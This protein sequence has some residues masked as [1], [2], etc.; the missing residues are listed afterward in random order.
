MLIPLETAMKR[1]CYVPNNSRPAKMIADRLV[2][3]KKP[4]R[5]RYLKMI[6]D[7]ATWTLHLSDAPLRFE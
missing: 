4:V 2:A 1:L 3:R 5:V 6:E 7:S